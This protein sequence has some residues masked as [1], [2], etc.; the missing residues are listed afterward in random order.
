M[1]TKLKLE[2][3]WEEYER[4]IHNDEIDHKISEYKLWVGEK[5]K[6][7]NSSF[8]SED[9]EIENWVGNINQE[10]V[11]QN[12]TEVIEYLESLKR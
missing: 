8:I 3:K 6:E 7:G 1:E 10:L 12:V 4:K 5:L 9:G 2:G 11:D